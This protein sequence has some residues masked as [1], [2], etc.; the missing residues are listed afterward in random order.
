MSSRIL[1]NVTP[2]ESRM[3]LVK[4]DLLYEYMLERNNHE[5][6][7]GNIF[8]GTVKNILNG[9]QAVFIDVGRDRNV[10]LYNGEEDTLSEGQSIVVQIIKDAMG[11]KGPRAIT[12]I[13]LPGRYVVFLPDA[14]YIGISR[15]ISCV[16]ERAR[17][18]SLVEEMKPA[19]AGIIV[20][21][22]A[23]SCTK[24]ELQKDIEYLNGLWQAITMRNARTKAPTLLYREVD[25]PIRVVR[26]YLNNDIDELIIDD[27]V[28][29]QRVKELVEYSYPSYQGKIIC[30]D[31]KK[32]IFSFYGVEQDIK[33]LVA[34]RVNLACGGYLIFD[35]TEA[36]TVIDVNTGSF[37][38]ESNLENTALVTN[39]QAA[40][41]IARQIRLRDIGG[42]IIIDFIDMHDLENRNEILQILEE[43]F[44]GDRMKP[45]VLGITNL[46]L[47][48]VT[49]R[50][51]RQGTNA[52]LFDDCPVCGGGGKVRSPEAIS[53]DIRRQL[54][55]SKNNNAVLL[56]AHPKVAEWFINNELP[57]LS[58]DRKVKV[59][60]V[61]D[62]HPECFTLLDAGDID[63]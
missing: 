54:R 44:V 51:A 25:L 55:E 48:E 11:S 10:F 12:Q 7:V 18:Q 29:Y 63:K 23:Q 58:K 57:R 31:N 62:M 26:D 53:V 47:V 41:E 59:Q 9:I 6:I 40:E 49:R 35:N 52:A 27:E 19:G 13:S 60:A 15:K 36:L 37:R 1:V 39:L 61:N 8:K 33:N 28:T 5:H 32:D 20:R 38:G 46:G 43:S 56:Q 24:E 16:E 17:L 34:R 22:V 30:H 2:E 45:R 42:I 4:N 3:V 50:K 21:T 14:D